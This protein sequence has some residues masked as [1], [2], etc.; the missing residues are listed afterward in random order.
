[1]QR[2]RVHVVRRVPV[3]SAGIACAT[4]TADANCNNGFCSAT[5]CYASSTINLAGNGDLEYGNGVGWSTNGG[6]PAL[7]NATAVPAG[8]VHTGTYAMGNITRTD[9]YNGPAY[10]IPTGAG[11][12]AIEPVGD[13][14]RERRTARGGAGEP[15]LRRR[16]GRLLPDVGTFGFNLP[17]GTWTPIS[18]TV[19]LATTSALCHPSAAT[20]GVVRSAAVYVNQFGDG[21]PAV[22]PNL[23]VDDL[24]VRVTDGHNLVGNPN[25]E[26]F[27]SVPGWAPPGL[28]KQ[29][30][31]HAGHHHLGVQDRRAG[32]GADRPGRHVQRPALE[33][34]AGCG[35]VQRERLRPAQRGRSRTT[36]FCSRRT[37][38]AGLGRSSRRRSPACRRSA[39]NWTQLSGTVTFPPANAPVGCR[40]TSAAVY[41]QQENGT[42][43]TLECPD[44]YIDDVS[45][46][47]AP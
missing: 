38:A 9:N 30:R 43:G 21:T 42:C 35:Q 15:G 26:A 23:F 6:R 29:R 7:Q 25:F 46:T 2:G 37:T 24:V 32:P 1:M 44:I 16:H 19:N 14:E 11:A 39:S 8:P 20:P 17:Q 4:C 36:W 45:I 10:A 13:A 5:A 28:A 41:V 33:P 27:D 34:A 47:L 31:R 18:G 22:R 3:R 40:L 12:Y